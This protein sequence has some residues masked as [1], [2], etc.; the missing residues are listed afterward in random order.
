MTKQEIFDRVWDWFVVKGMPLS[1]DGLQCRLR[2]NG[3]ADDLV[4]CALGLF[5]PDEKYDPSLEAMV[6]PSRALPDER[7]R[8][9]QVTGLSSEGLDFALRLQSAH[10]TTAST[11]LDKVTARAD[12]AANLRDVAAGYEILIPELPSGV[13]STQGRQRFLKP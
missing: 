3:C 4:R 7:E 11:Y 1:T 9:L 2:K 10:D 6:P 12:I 8:L 5:V 13:E